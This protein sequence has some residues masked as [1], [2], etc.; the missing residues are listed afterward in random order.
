MGEAAVARRARALALTPWAYLLV[1]LALA[2]APTRPL[3]HDEAVYALGARD[4]VDGGGDGLPL[5]RSIGMMAAAAPGVLAGGGELALRLP[6]ALYAL[7]YVG[8]IAALTRRTFGAT[9]AVIA[10]AVQV[11]IP[12]FSWR[13]AEA[14]SDIPA[15]LGLLALVAALAGPRPRPIVAAAAAAA[16]CYLRYASAPVV[17]VVMVAAFVIYPERRRA[18][19]IAAALALALLVPFFVWSRAITG[20]VL[21]VLHEGERLA[22]RDYPGHGLVFYLRAWPVRLA[23]PVAGLIAAAGVVV[24][25]A[26]WRRSVDPAVQLRRLLVVA[27]LGQIV[28]L[29]WRVHGE[30]RFITFALTALIVVAASWLA[31]APARARIALALAAVAAVPSA[32][33]TL[34]RLDQLAR[35]RAPAVVAARAIA[36]DRAGRPCLV[37][38]TE[39]PMVAWYSGCR[40]AQVDGWGLDVRPAI[41]V[42]PVYLLDAVGLRFRMPGAVAADRLGWAPLA[43]GHPRAWAWRATR[44]VRSAAP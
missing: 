43:T 29:G 15:A 26:A 34:R 33:W 6:F 25:L 41:G 27:A 14:L 20:S 42:A 36:A 35:D 32:V 3:G 40:A 7:A 12:E 39:P 2:L 17:A 19:V 16:A 44:A 21:G 37:Y 18:I 23:G 38:T 28:L 22:R 30:A 5:H 13:A 8:L 10:I 4:L 31:A 11:T 1:V 24:G 9:A